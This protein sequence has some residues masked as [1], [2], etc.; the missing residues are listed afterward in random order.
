MKTPRGFVLLVVLV[1]LAAISVATAAR[2]EVLRSESGTTTRREE[3]VAA[4]AW[5]EACM[6]KAYALVQGYLV[7]TSTAQPM[8]PVD[9][10]ALLDPDPSSTGE[11]N[12]PGA[13]WTPVTIRG[14]RFGLL[15]QAGS[16][17]QP[18]LAC[19]LRFEDN[20]D[21]AAPS[22]SS[23]PE[24]ATSNTGGVLEGPD[25]L[26][27]VPARDRDRSIVVTAIGVAPFPSTSV[28]D[29]DVYARAH[30]R[31][32]LKR[33]F[34]SN[35]APAVFAGGDAR[36][37][38]VSVCGNGGVQADE[39][40][41]DDNS[42]ACGSVVGEP[43]GDVEQCDDE[44]LDD[45]CDAEGLRCE[46]LDIVPPGS[47]PN[48]PSAPSTAFFMSVPSAW[49]DAPA[50]K[51]GD[52]GTC[53]LWLSPKSGGMPAVMYVWDRTSPTCAAA[54]PDPVPAP[55]PYD[56]VHFPTSASLSDTVAPVPDPAA[57]AAP[58]SC[59]R[60]I[61]VDDGFGYAW[62]QTNAVG[63]VA[64]EKARFSD[65]KLAY[66]NTSMSTGQRPLDDPGSLPA[67]TWEALCTGAS[68]GASVASDDAF[69]WDAGGA[70]WRVND[71]D[72]D[73]LPRPAVFGVDGAI[74]VSDNVGT[75]TPVHWRLMARGRIDLETNV[76]MCCPTCRC[77]TVPATPNDCVQS[78]TTVRSFFGTSAPLPPLP[79]PRPGVVLS[80]EALCRTDNAVSLY[81]RAHC[82]TFDGNNRSCLLGGL[83]TYG[84]MP[85]G[86]NCAATSGEATGCNTAIG[87]CLKNEARVV[88]D[89]TAQGSI[90]VN[91]NAEVA[92]TVWT[93]GDIHF[94]NNADIQGQLVAGGNVSLDEGSQVTFNGQGGIGGGA[95]SMAW[96]EAGW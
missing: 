10:D 66:Q 29:A 32:T 93:N 3:E 45:E 47:H 85:V 16:A 56:A 17:T 52:P 62:E 46:D 9:F 80:S 43:G 33:W 86:A 40:E 60:P 20:A 84:T 76:R 96:A 5:A 79:S 48:P 61:F 8:P 74:L 36:F 90:C 18:Q 42:C 35:G 53:K 19:L 24:A 89:M 59:W 83:A 65:T 13:P 67:L 63:P 87:T 69:H 88:G 75:T 77:A 94:E 7:H 2:L 39:S 71:V 54:T 27:D 34:Q 12:T 4:R 51:L 6:E 73:A 78:N 38:N 50:T 82:A 28:A 68:T 15:R 95:R 26:A 72:R 30:A 44:D 21:D 11:E 14:K 64:S 81:G 55:C 37:K 92:G 25:A 31:V 22:G 91:K 41:F 49:I 70:R 1:L 23:H 57:C 58:A